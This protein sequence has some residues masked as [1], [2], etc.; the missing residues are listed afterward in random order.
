MQRLLLTA[1]LL[2]LT[3][4]AS[5]DEVAETCIRCHKDALTLAGR[6]ADELA[7]R[8][9]DMRDGRGEHIVAIPDLSDDELAALAEQLTSP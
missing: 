2:A 7:A 6:P 5:A 9:R 1:A 4:A 8:L 3:A